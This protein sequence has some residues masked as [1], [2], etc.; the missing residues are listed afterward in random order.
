MEQNHLRSIPLGVPICMQSSVNT[1]HV[2][3][4]VHSRLAAEQKVIMFYIKE[5]FMVESI[6]SMAQVGFLWL[7]RDHEELLPAWIIADLNQRKS[8]RDSMIGE[9]LRMPLIRPPEKPISMPS[10]TSTVLILPL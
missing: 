10:P 4:I 2:F 6:P 5:G 8:E 7:K 3:I 9:E 1:R